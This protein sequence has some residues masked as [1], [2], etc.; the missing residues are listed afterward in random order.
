M[1]RILDLSGSIRSGF[2]TS[3]SKRFLDLKRRIE[4]VSRPKAKAE[5]FLAMEKQEKF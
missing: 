5:R 2:F 1:A 4:P 3:F